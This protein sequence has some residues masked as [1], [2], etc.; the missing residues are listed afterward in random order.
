MTLASTSTLTIDATTLRTLL[1]DPGVEI[2]L[3]DAR[4]AGVHARDGHILLSVSLP[5]SQIEL[6]V[7]SLVP[8]R[9]TRVVVYDADGGPLAARAAQRLR[10][11]GY[12]DVAILAGGT[13][14]WVEA[15]YALFTGVNVIGKA[16]GEY[17][18][19]EYGTP[20]IS[21]AEAKARIDAG[22]NVV[23][24]DSRPV[25][26]FRNFSI[27]GAVDLPGA[28]LVHRFHAAVPDENTLVVV[29]CAGRTRSIIGAQALI[30]AGVPNRVVSLANGTMDWLI[31]GHALD[32]GR[33]NLGPAPAGKALVRAQAA[34]RRLVEHFGIRRVD[35]TALRAFEAEAA[36]ERR[37]LYLLDVRTTEEFERGHLPGSRSAP[38]GQ[39]VQ[40]SGDWVGTQRARIVLIDEP[41]GVRA[42]ITASWLIQINQAEVYVLT[43]ALEGPLAVGPEQSLLA[44]PI[45]AVETIDATS[46]ATRLQAR[47]VTLLDLGS[48]VAYEKAHIP[49]ALFV[50]R[51]RLVEDAASLPG[52]GALVLTSPDGLLAAFAAAEL[53]GATDRPVLVLAGGTAGWT[54][55]GRPL[56]TGRAAAFHPTEDVARSAYLADGDRFAA[57]RAYLDWELSL[58]EQLERDGTTRFRRFPPADATAGFGSAA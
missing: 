56:A 21:V 29:N 58:V 50:I 25:A 15:G 36:A 43:D 26:E 14:S 1:V 37:S 24:I 4:E 46:L 31:A 2:A 19:H 49:G 55:A 5:L 44:A 10:T 51:S 53:Q 42:A 33:D 47:D 39:L 17:V 38:G 41:D 8:R 45:P 18:E 28:E 34:T 6:R 11:L 35:R 16:F 54:Q 32:S 22:D 9:N 7:A 12:G 13:A 20:H 57:F 52:D 27:P 48:S 40:Q 3:L 23:V 30:N